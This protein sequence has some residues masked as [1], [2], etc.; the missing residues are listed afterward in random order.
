MRIRTLFLKIFIWFWMAAAGIIGV[1][2]LM[3]WI[4]DAQTLPE[5]ITRGPLSEVLNM[6]ADSAI[7]AYEQEGIADDIC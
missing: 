6:Y 3:A 4:S 1:L 2:V 5:R 7:R